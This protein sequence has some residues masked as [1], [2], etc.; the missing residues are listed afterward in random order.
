[1]GDVNRVKAERIGVL[2][3]GQSSEREISLKSGRCVS[4]ALTRLGYDTVSIDVSPS[5]S[6]VI[7][8]EAVDLAFLALHGPGGED[9]A[10]QGFL[11][12]I[13][14]PYTGSGVLASAIGMDKAVTKA[15][16]AATGVPMPP[17]LVFRASDF[18]AVRPVTQT[19]PF[20]FPVLVKPVAEGSSVGVSV[21][22]RI[23]D[24]EQ[25]YCVA[26]EFGHGVLIEQFIDGPEFTVGIVDEMPLPVIE[27]LVGNQ[28]FDFQTKYDDSTTPHAC[29]ATLSADRERSMQELGLRVHQS[30]GCR[31]ASRIDVRVDKGGNPFVLEIN[32]IPGMTKESLLPLAAEAAGIE[33]DRLVEMLLR[34]AE[35]AR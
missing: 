30:I 14:I 33:Y 22:H 25:A 32:T 8:D 31:G 26:S 35:G 12:T 9:G 1:M 34:S 11:E 16:L 23:E 15:V 2:M 6:E 19:L 17:S 10:I 5:L 18:S 4:D 13:G 7:R 24:I 3:G 28:V 29:R 21:A 27:I 20:S